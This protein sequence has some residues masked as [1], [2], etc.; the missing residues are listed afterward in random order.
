MESPEGPTPSSAG[1][2]TALQI[3]I[4]FAKHKDTR[5]QIMNHNFGG[6]VNE[7]LNM[8]KAGSTDFNRWQNLLGIDT[9]YGSTQSLVCPHSAPSSPCSISPRLLLPE[10]VRTMDPTGMT[11]DYTE[12]LPH[13]GE[14]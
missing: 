8:L 12:R 10:V 9:A 7:L 2:R 6:I 11:K 4:A 5:A 3:L 13:A 14:S 1:P